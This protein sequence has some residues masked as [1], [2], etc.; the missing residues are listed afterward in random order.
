MFVCSGL[1]S[2]GGDHRRKGKG[3]TPTP[4]VVACVGA[5]GLR[6]FF[7]KRWIHTRVPIKKKALGRIT[8]LYEIRVV[9]LSERR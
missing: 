6:K 7:V 3:R 9:I 2:V 5:L 1:R 8:Y 4:K